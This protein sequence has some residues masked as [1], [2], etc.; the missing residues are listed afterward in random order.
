MLCDDCDRLWSEGYT[1]IQKGQ[2]QQAFFA[3]P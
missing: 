3:L 2:Q 1:T